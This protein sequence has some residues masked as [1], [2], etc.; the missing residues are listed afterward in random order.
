M[1]LINFTT[2]KTWNIIDFKSP[3]P[4]QKKRLNLIIHVTVNWLVLKLDYTYNAHLQHQ[5]RDVLF[6]YYYPRNSSLIK[7]D[8]NPNFF[9]WSTYF[10]WQK[11]TKKLILL[12]DLACPALDKIQNFARCNWCNVTEKWIYKQVNQRLIVIY[13]DW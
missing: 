1:I 11:L 10:E 6:Y 4:Y 3:L 8:S 2:S 9:F 5:I 13:T 7:R 12:F